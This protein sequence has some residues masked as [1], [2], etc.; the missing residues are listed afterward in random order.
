MNKKVN[1]FNELAKVTNYQINDIWYNEEK[2]TFSLIIRLNSD[3]YLE[4]LYSFY[5]EF[6][7]LKELK[8]YHEVNGDVIYYCL[9]NNKNNNY[10][11]VKKDFIIYEAFTKDFTIK[12]AF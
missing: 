7:T 11:E 12:K 8:E 10:N 6:N 5:K 9:V 3:N 4:S 1:C 2:K